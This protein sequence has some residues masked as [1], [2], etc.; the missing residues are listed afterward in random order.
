MGRGSFLFYRLS[1]IFTFVGGLK[2]GNFILVIK[3]NVH[4]LNVIEN[5]ILIIFL[6]L[7][8]P[9]SRRMC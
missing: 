7:C 6:W 8:L 3:F 2:K 5:G 9:D 1:G 4:N